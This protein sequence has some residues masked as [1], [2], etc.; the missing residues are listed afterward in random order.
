M[1]ASE[2]AIPEELLR[3]ILSYSLRVHPK[4]FLSFRQDCEAIF[5]VPTPEPTTKETE[6]LPASHL[7]LVSKRWLRVG[8]PLLYESVKVST[9]AHLSTLRTLLSSSPEVGHAVRNLRL[10]RVYNTELEPTLGHMPNLC[11]LYLY[12]GV[13]SSCSNLG[14]LRVLP[15]LQVHN[16]YVD[17]QGWSSRTRMRFRPGVNVKTKAIQS[18]VADVIKNCPTLVSVSAIIAC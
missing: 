14:L 13:P 2:K 12:V 7:M 4:E 5:M 10:E 18:A 8:T 9:P 16:L 15:K 6:K 17:W 11:A 3:E 1:P